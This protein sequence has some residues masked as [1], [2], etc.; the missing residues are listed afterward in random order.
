MRPHAGGLCTTGLAA[1]GQPAR[2]TAR[3]AEAVQHHQRGTDA[4]EAV[5][6]IERRV[7]PALLPVHLDEIDDMAVDQPVDHIAQRAADDEGGS[8]V[9]QRAELALYDL[10]AQPA[11]YRKREAGEEELLPAAG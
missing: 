3:L 7:V 5:G 11:R 10:P 1:R 2:L 6:N 4:D 9:H 8:P